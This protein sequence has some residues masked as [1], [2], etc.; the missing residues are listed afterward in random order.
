V[1]AEAKFSFGKSAARHVAGVSEPSFP[2]PSV[3]VAIGRALSAVG[4]GGVGSLPFADFA[5]MAC[6]LSHMWLSL[7]RNHL[8]VSIYT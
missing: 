1:L 5:G 2:D 8:C 3:R 4:V 6:S 7:Y